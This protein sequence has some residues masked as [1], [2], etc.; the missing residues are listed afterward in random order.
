[1]SP[2]LD[3]WPSKRDHDICNDILDGHPRSQVAH[4]H[5]LAERTISEITRR[6]LLFRA[7]R[8]A[9]AFPPETH[10]AEYDRYLR[11]VR[12]PRE[13]P[14]LLDRPAMDAI[15]LRRLRRAGARLR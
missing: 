14:R 1:M 8:H 2:P 12:P 6:V 4:R 11:D 7:E 9:S 10:W 15:Q 5:S 13:S 3:Y